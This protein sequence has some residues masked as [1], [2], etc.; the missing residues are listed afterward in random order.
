MNKPAFFISGEELPRNL[1]FHGLVIDN[2]TCSWRMPHRGRQSTQQ[3]SQRGSYRPPSISPPKTRIKGV[4]SPNLVFFVATVESNSS[5]DR[6][7]SSCGLNLRQR[8]ES[9]DASGTGSGKR[10]D[11]D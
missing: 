5:R 3:P 7:L 4:T 11:R 9:D 8:R 6:A 10:T 2:H 1:L